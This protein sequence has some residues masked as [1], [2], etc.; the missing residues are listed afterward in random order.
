MLEET[1]FTTTFFYPPEEQTY[2]PEDEENSS[3]RR[4]LA[5]WEASQRGKPSD[6]NRR[7]DNDAARQDSDILG[8]IEFRL[9]PNPVQTVLTFEFHI[10]IDAKASYGLY[11]IG[12]IQ[13]YRNA[14]R[15]YHAGKH[16]ETIEMNRFPRGTYIL[17]LQVNDKMFSE[18]VIKK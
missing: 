2:L 12:G 14:A 1:Y 15:N 10:P 11:N 5:A 3:K 4:E 17:Q 6:S 16:S 13:L 8:D 9:Y 7:S 18:K